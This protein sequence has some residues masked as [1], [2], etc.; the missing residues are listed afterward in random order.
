MQDLLRHTPKETSQV[1]NHIRSKA[2]QLKPDGDT[3]KEIKFNIL[4]YFWQLELLGLVRIEVD[5]ISL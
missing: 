5:T 2:E 1:T 3:N 4:H